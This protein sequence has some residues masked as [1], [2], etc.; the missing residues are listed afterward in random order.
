MPSKGNPH[1][2]VSIKDSLPKVWK[3][4]M[5]IL[6]YVPLLLVSVVACGNTAP[7]LD[8]T[9]QW[10]M[11][12]TF[13]NGTIMC[14]TVG[15]LLLNHPANGTRFTGQRATVSQVCTGNRPDG[16]DAAPSAGVFNANVRGLR[17]TME[18]DFCEFDG[19]LENESQMSGTLE[20]PDGLGGVPDV[21]TG[22]WQA[23]RR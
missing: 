15:D 7:E 9:G 17:V 21:F 3:A 22:T 11:L 20:C 23:T 14:E 12:Q 6:R 1:G 10:D 16:F 5:N 13:T 8:V 2:L 19:M 18:I 4:D